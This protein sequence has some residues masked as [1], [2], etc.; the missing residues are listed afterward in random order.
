MAVSQLVCPFIIGGR[1]VCSHLLGIINNA[2]INICVQ[3]SLWMYVFIFLEYIYTLECNCF[4]HM[5]IPCITCWGTTK[6][7]S[8]WLHH[9]TFPPAVCEWVYLLP[10]SSPASFVSWWW[11]RLISGK[12]VAAVI[13]LLVKLCGKLNNEA[14]LFCRTYCVVA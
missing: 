8:Q 11:V 4:G 14:P 7:F 3:I 2:A 13:H 5:V 9:F 10:H 1:L 12:L 6:L